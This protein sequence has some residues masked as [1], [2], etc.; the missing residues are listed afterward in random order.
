MNYIEKVV[1]TSFYKSDAMDF[2]VDMTLDLPEA[3]L[4]AFIVPNPTNTFDPHAKRIEIVNPF[5]PDVRHHIGYLGKNSLLYNATKAYTRNEIPCQVNVKAWSTQTK[6]GK[7][8]ND[9]YKV[10]LEYNRSEAETKLIRRIT[11]DS[12][13][14]SAHADAQLATH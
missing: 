5:N 13:I 7:P 3:T 8:M 14:A 9:S 11:K 6:K 2:N 4:D 10:I 12:I 1:G